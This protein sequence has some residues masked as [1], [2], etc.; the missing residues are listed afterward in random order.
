MSILDFIKQ[1]KEYFE[2]FTTRATHH[3]NGIE[4]SA[5][6][7]A[8]TYAI[9]FNQSDVKVSAEPREFYEAVNHKYGIDYIFNQ[10]SDKLA[11]SDIVSI[12]KI[13]NKN[14]NEIGGYRTAQVFIRGAEHIPPAPNQVP[15]LMKY[16]IDN[17]NNTVF[18]DIYERVAHFHIEFERIHPFS[19]GNG[20]TGR[21]LIC[22]ELI[23]ND[24]APSVITKDDK[25]EYL[26]FIS[27][28]D[29]KSL[30]K[31][32]RKLSENEQARIDLFK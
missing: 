3:S 4:G 28:Q 12:A 1:N 31:L 20:R 6:S 15:M 21:L 32:L 10:M 27:N 18:D 29:V 22:Y 13:V 26:N 9:I 5:L 25:I 30:A 24:V 2:D 7:M 8:E 11:E 23:K 17:Y 19:D 16:F 14:I